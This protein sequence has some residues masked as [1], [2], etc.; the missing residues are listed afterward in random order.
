MSN[1]RIRKIGERSLGIDDVVRS[2]VVGGEP[3]CRKIAEA[4][5]KLFELHR[6]QSDPGR[7]T[8]AAKFRE[9]VRHAFERLEQMECGNAAAR[10]GKTSFFAIGTHGIA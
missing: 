7:L 2:Q 5:A 8:M 6:V 4:A 10:S 9:Q 3:T 1:Q